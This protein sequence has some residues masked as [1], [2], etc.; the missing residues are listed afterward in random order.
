MQIATQKSTWPQWDSYKPAPRL[1]ARLL[2]VFFMLVGF[3]VVN[4]GTMVLAGHATTLSNPFSTYADILPGQH[5]SAVVARGFS[6]AMDYLLSHDQYCTLD[7]ETGISSQVGVVISRGAVRQTDFYLREN[8][9]RIGDL[10]LL[11]GTP[12]LRYGQSVATFIWS[13]SG[14]SAWGVFSSGRNPLLLP[15]QGVSFRDTRT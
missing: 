6:C 13:G 14:V 11:W 4:V 9:L 2:V 8:T 12:D 15:V 10:A 3:T 5:R 7:L 1:S